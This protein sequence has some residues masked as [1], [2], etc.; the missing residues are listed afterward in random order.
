MITHDDVIHN[1]AT[2]G[3]DRMERDAAQ[4]AATGWVPPGPRPLPVP[5]DDAEQRILRDLSI[6][7]SI[8]FYA[9]R[10]CINAQSYAVGACATYLVTHW[11][12][13]LPRI[14]RQIHHELR[15]AL[16][17]GHVQDPIDVAMWQDVLRLPLEGGAP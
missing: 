9:F 4:F 10:Y 17:A 3:N 8:V 16:D 5:P 13:L 6:S 1:S 2:M 12:D 7:D 11:P 15:A 14:Q